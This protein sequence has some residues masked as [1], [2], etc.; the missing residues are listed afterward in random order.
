MSQNKK[1]IVIEQDA[2]PESSVG[3]FTKVKV[4]LLLTVISVVIGAF[5][6]PFGWLFFLLSVVIA[7]L[8]MKD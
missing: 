5:S 2:E 4:Y 7:H 3:F 8:V 6:A 1:Y